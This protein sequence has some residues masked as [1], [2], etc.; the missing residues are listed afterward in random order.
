M[1]EYS[2]SGKGKGKSEDLE[3]KG[4]G[5]EV[6]DE[7]ET[8][9]RPKG[10]SVTYMWKVKCHRCKNWGHYARDCPSE[11]NRESSGEFDK[12]MIQCY[13]CRKWGHYAKDCRSNKADDRDEERRSWKNKIQCFNC[14]K[15]GHYAKECRWK[16]TDYG[17]YSTYKQ[18]YPKYSPPPPPPVLEPEATAK[19]ETV[20]VACI[21][22]KKEAAKYVQRVR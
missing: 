13:N 15:W 16:K 12:K 22:Q 19:A 9:T 17:W 6:E 1:E 7:Q 11:C 18:A 14:Q 10:K 21:D 2:R 4:K 5:D 3:E 20:C 8:S